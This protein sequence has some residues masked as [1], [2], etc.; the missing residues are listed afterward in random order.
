ML[1]LY[2][3]AQTSEANLLENK[4]KESR[5]KLQDI[6]NEIKKYEQELYRVSKEK[7]TLKNALYQIDLSKKKVQN[8][9]YL[10][11][12]KINKIQ[13]NISEL[14]GDIREKEEKIQLNKEGL[15]AIMRDFDRMENKS[16]FE[17][18]SGGNISD[19]LFDVEN[20]KKFQEVIKKENA[21]LRKQKEDLRYNK[22]QLEIQK[23]ELAKEK[24]KLVQERR[25][26]L[27]ARKAQADLIKKT[28]NKESNYQ[29]LLE[30]KRRAKKEFESQLLE[31]ESKLKYILNPDEL[32]TVGTSVLS[33]PLSKVRISQY[34]GNTKFAKSGAYNGKGHNGIDMATPIG[35]P[36]KA[37]LSGVVVETGNTD[38]YKGCYSY[39]KWVLVKHGNGLSTL[40]AHL[41]DFV[42]KAGDR[43][44]TNQTIA[45]SGNTGYSTGPHLHFTVYASKA[46]KVMRLGDIK[47]RTNCANAR[48]P[49]APLNAYM[50]PIDF[51]RKR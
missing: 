23:R 45:F 40:Y 18:F 41:S 24:D 51:L 5:D 20:I 22:D 49:I 25:S 14:S 10:T 7:K 2:I 31:Y 3:Y 17:M 8:Q 13:T 12:S 26:I 1:P 37:A 46:V 47:R 6:E 28:Q 50:N 35:T 15:A 30:E 9:I 42:V 27:I 34:F 21:S 48:I 36:V 38:A 16:F 33:W 11:Q 39:G 19:L 4:I 44:S 43:V 32:P 29:K